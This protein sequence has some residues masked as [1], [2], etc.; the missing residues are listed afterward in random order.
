MPIVWDIGM[1]RVSKGVMRVKAQLTVAPFTT[2]ETVYAGFDEP[3]T[4]AKCKDIGDLVCELATKA[5]IN[6]L[7]VN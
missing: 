1:R 2:Y 6:W 4:D 5:N 7:C 3:V